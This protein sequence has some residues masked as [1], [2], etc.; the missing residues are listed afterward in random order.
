M[1]SLAFEPADEEKGVK[2]SLTSEASP[3]KAGQPTLKLIFALLSILFL[4]SCYLGYFLAEAYP[5]LAKKEMEDLREFF[6][7]FVSRDISPLEIFLIIFLNNSIKSFFA[8][9]LGVFFGIVPVLFIFLNG[10][11]IG[12]FAKFL[13]EEMGILKFVFLL[14]PHGIL[15]IPAVILACSYGVQL[16]ISLIKDRKGLGK[17]IKVSVIKFFKIVVPMLFVAAAVETLLIVIR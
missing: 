14:L 11:I 16:G 13:G 8:M 6:R 3:L 1:E 5:D 12:F 2:P 7:T 4:G 9:I 10:L 15:E 17:K